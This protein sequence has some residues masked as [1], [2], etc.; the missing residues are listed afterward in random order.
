[1]PSAL[2]SVKD[3]DLV[4]PTQCSTPSL[5][6]RSFGANWE[7]KGHE[8]SFI[9]FAFVGPS[10]FPESSHVS[11]PVASLDGPVSQGMFSGE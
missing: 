5:F 3:L 9:H 4:I 2:V 10:S 8:D 6:M 7:G 11:L 1:M